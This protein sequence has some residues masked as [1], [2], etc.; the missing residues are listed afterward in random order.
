MRVAVGN[1]CLFLSAA[2]LPAAAGVLDGVT[3]GTWQGEV[4][5]AAAPATAVPDRFLILDSGG[6]GGGFGQGDVR[7][8]LHDVHFWDAR[9]GWAC[10]YGGVFRTED[11]GLTWT[12]M[13]P[14][15][16]WYQI[17]MTGPQEIWLEEGKHPGG[18]GN[19][20]LWHSTDGGVNW[21]EELAGKLAGYHSLYCH[22]AERWVLCGSYP[23]Y[24][25]RDGGRN[26]E[27]AN[28]GGLLQGAHRIAIPADLPTPGGF[29]VYVAGSFGKSRRLIRSDDGGGTWRLLPLP[30]APAHW[31]YVPFFAT[32]RT[33][34]LGAPDGSVLYT[35]DGGETWENRSLPTNQG[36]M[37]LWFDLNGRGFAAVDNTN[38]MHPRGALFETTDGG[39][40]WG[41]I[42]GGQKH[43]DR[44]F[45]LGPDQ[46]WIVGDVPGYIQ[47]DLVG[48]LIGPSRE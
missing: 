8:K 47:N 19:A 43:I 22:G 10:G 9:H 26:W 33:G 17:E 42:L 44:I 13:K 2:A 3:P 32:S 15:G 31:R 40:N 25:S 16:G 37:S 5:S 7:H 41:E 20:W 12:R 23:S 14:G 18:S 38:F 34:W 46:I 29:T 45:G 35:A 36:I 24:H 21:Q 4:Y 28:F 30:D 11:G 48:I 39:R 27:Q 1:L 6:S